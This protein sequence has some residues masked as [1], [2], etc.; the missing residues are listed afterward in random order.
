MQV[1]VCKNASLHARKHAAFQ[2]GEPP[3]PLAPNMRT[4]ARR[5]AP[6][7]EPRGT[8]GSTR[9]GG[10]SKKP[11]NIGR[12]RFNPLQIEGSI[13]L[14]EPGTEASAKFGVWDVERVEAALHPSKLDAPFCE[15]ECTE[16]AFRCQG[17]KALPVV[18]SGSY[19]FEARRFSPIFERFPCGAVGGAAA[20]LPACGG[21]ERC[22]VPG[23]GVGSPGPGGHTPVEQQ[24][25]LSNLA[26]ERER[27]SATPPM[28]VP[29]TMA[30]LNPRG[31]WQVRGFQPKKPAKQG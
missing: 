10:D 14:D 8:E 16:S 7:L 31:P 21:L 13:L 3:P 25:L 22:H 6:Q 27:L 5:W 15:A 30:R 29:S 18:Q 24:Q 4:L 11:R 19:Q 28:R 20:Q 12:F 26:R 2:E 17:L 23:H 1:L 9:G